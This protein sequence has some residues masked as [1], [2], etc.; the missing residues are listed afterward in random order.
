MQKASAFCALLETY[1][2]REFLFPI[3]IDGGLHHLNSV[4]LAERFEK[5][6]EAALALKIAFHR[7]PFVF[8]QRVGDLAIEGPS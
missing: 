1:L 8:Q 4:F 6:A 2:T 7:L 5:M 3:L